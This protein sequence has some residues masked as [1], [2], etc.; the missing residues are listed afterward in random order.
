MD[1]QKT[2][3]GN[4]QN[5]QDK[6]NSVQ[7]NISTKVNQFNKNDVED[8]DPIIEDVMEGNSQKLTQDDQILSESQKMVEDEMQFA[9][10][11]L[12]YENMDD[13]KKDMEEK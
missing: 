10:T 11:S 1:N 7:P 9:P 5:S 4:L 8:A 2:E 6:S 3:C 13:I 12:S